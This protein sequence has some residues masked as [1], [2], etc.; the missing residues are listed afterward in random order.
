[1][2]AMMLKFRMCATSMNLSLL[3]PSSRKDTGAASN[4]KAQS[5][6]RKVRNSDFKGVTS[7]NV[8]SFPSCAT[9]HLADHA[10]HWRSVASGGLA[11]CPSAFWGLR[12][13]GADT[14]PRCAAHND[15][16]PALPDLGQISRPWEPPRLRMM[17]LPYSIRLDAPHVNISGPERKEKP[18]FADDSQW[19]I[20]FEADINVRCPEIRD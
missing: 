13:T 15:E 20:N 1:M 12:I 11:P 8:P 16:S 10:G 9:A 4:F 14:P 5:L 2:W 7:P 6:K 19:A 18:C 17:P 3:R